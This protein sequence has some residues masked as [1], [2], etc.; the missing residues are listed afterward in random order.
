MLS[1]LVWSVALLLHTW[2]ATPHSWLGAPVPLPFEVLAK[3]STPM[4]NAAVPI[5]VA[6]RD[7]GVA[8]L[9]HQ[10]L[11]G[12]VGAGGVFDL[13]GGPAPVLG[14]RVAVV[15]RQ[16]RWGTHAAGADV[17]AGT[18]IAGVAVQ[19]RAAGA[20]AILALVGYRAGRI[21]V[22]Q[23]T[24]DRVGAAVGGAQVV[25]SRVIVAAVDGQ[26]CAWAVSRGGNANPLD[27]ATTPAAVH[28]EV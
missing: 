12:A 18:G 23:T 4:P 6:L 20:S 16:C 21:V 10:A 13:A 9:V 11:A 7:G 5:A 8:D 22:A 19:R 26:A 17:G 3:G 27:V 24:V 25:G 2:N 14:D 15:A 28:G 1:S